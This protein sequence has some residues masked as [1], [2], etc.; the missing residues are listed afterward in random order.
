MVSVYKRDFKFYVGYNLTFKGHHLNVLVLIP[1]K[2]YHYFCDYSNKI[3][4][5]GS[6]QNFKELMLFVFSRTQ[7]DFTT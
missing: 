5:D 2:H 1:S 7:C 4:I 3:C 6:D